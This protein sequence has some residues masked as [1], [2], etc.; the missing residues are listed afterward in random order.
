MSY[1]FN[2]YALKSYTMQKCIMLTL[3]EL[4]YAKISLTIMLSNDILYKNISL[5]S[6]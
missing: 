1:Q 4:F 2:N 6:F 5:Q 3:V